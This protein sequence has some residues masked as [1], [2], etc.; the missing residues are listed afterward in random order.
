[1]S[2]DRMVNE[3]RSFDGM[4]IGRGNGST[5]VIGSF[6]PSSHGSLELYSRWGYE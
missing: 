5:W 4:I 3:R 2:N 1:V 6:L